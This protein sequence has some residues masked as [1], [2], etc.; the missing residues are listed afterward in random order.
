MPA[1]H[2]SRV[3]V[4]QPGVAYTPVALLAFPVLVVELD[5]LTVA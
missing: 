3:G 1:P 4:V 2:Q 5:T